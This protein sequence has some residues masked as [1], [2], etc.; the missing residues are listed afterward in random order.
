MAKRKNK[1]LG[2]VLG[3]GGARGIAH[4]GFLQALDE[5]GIKPG[6]IAGCSM[7]SVVGGLYSKGM[8][9]E[10]ML[11]VVKK[12]K[13]TDVI[14]LSVSGFL[15]KSILKTEK[16]KKLLEKLFGGVKFKDLKTQFSCNAFDIV[17]G[18]PVWFN[19]KNC[20]D[21][22]VSEAVR[23]SSSIPIVFQPLET[24]DKKI[25]IDGGVRIR[26]PIEAVKTMGADV[27]V[28]V[29]VL[30][31]LRETFKDKNIIDRSL[32][33]IDA[34]DWAQ[35]KKRYEKE[36]YDLLLMPDLGEMSQYVVKDLLFVYEKGYE[37]G[38][39]NVEK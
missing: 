9:P 15:A 34:M 38:V 5:N 13:P 39:E 31:K 10:E 16:M 36:K 2:L 21:L 24:P 3:S 18:E 33:I 17:G 22:E 28:G 11:S 14:D 23:A 27:I 29:D 26:M 37:L 12:L 8:K 25:L 7:G 1:K 32:R 19:K 35:T 20:P 4:V 6:C 30:G